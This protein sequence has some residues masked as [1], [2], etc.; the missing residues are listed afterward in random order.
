MFVEEEELIKEF[1]G[2]EGMKPRLASVLSQKE[3]NQR[4]SAA[5]SGN[6][7][8]RVKQRSGDSRPR[9]GSPGPHSCVWLSL[10]PGLSPA[11]QGASIVSPGG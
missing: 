10:A 11:L 8:G 9:L 7:V 1:Q 6:T 3:T 2:K 4:E 5:F